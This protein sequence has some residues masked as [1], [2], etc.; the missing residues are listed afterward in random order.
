MIHIFCIVIDLS[1]NF[2][3]SLIGFIINT[4]GIWEELAVEV[5]YPYHGAPKA[6]T[7]SSS[8][9]FS[10]GLDHD[11]LT[12]CNFTWFIS[13]QSLFSISIQYIRCLS[14]NSIYMVTKLGLKFIFLLL[15]PPPFLHC[16]ALHCS[17][18]TTKNITY[19]T[20]T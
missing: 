18:K 9:M 20:T 5:K 12:L 6:P 17:A 16:T 2:Q 3:T 13:N 7:P 19:I 4:R 15:F 14:H 1:F 10:W 8:K 11:Q